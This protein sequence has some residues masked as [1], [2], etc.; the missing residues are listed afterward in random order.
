[1]LRKRERQ[2]QLAALRL[3]G[4]RN[5]A[6]HRLDVHFR[7]GYAWFAGHPTL[8]RTHIDQRA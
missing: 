6:L 8:Q 3:S 5:V 1:M 2:Q 7:D 4:N